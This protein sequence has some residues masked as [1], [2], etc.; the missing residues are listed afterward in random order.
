MAEQKRD[1]YEVLGV[2]KDADDAALKK[3]YRV[4]AKK[5]HPDANPG[6]K[7]AEAAFKE[8]NEAYSVL[9]DPKKRAQ[10]DQFGHA[11]F[12]PRMGGG[13]GGGFYEGS[14]ADFGDI[15]GDLFGGGDIFGSFFGGGRGTQRAAN[16]PMR[17]ANVHATVRLSFEEAVFGCKKKITIDYK[18]ECETCK[19][20]GAKPGTSPETCPTCK[21]QGKIVKTSRTAF[22]T[23]QNVQ[24][25]P[26]CH[27]SG[28][29]V[30]E[31]CTSCNG[32]GYKRVRKS[33]EVSIPAGIDNGLSVRMP[34]GGEPGVNGG[35]RGDLLVECIVSPHPIFKRQESN[36]FST[37]PISFATAALG[38]TIRINTVDGEVE[39]TVKAGTQTDTRVRLAGK[40]VPS[41]R[42]PKVRGDH[43]VTLVVEVPTKLNE[44]QRAALKSFDEAMQGGGK[45]KGL[46]S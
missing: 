32:T 11:A 37:V 24:V 45:K 13:S 4:L 39:Y 43:Y 23:M 42:N 41:L 35:E 1:Y 3:A 10:Y 25:C 7:Q 36:I 15:F 9:S 16:A 14:A 26:N 31:K 29:V 17:G 33:F 27:G 8:I 38:G 28:K 40:G 22:G 5:Y 6:D 2:S 34:Q 21:G 19:G 18:E 46:F 44:Q 12:D 20:S 30:K